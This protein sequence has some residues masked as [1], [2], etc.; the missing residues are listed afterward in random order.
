MICLNILITI[1]IIIPQSF[2]LETKTGG[3]KKVAFGINSTQPFRYMPSRHA[4]V[5][6]L[7]KIKNYRNNPKEVN[8]LVV[9]INKNGNLEKS[10]PCKD[11]I[12]MMQMSNF[13]IKYIYY[14]T[15]DGIIVKEKFSK[16]MDS[17]LTY[18]SKGVKSKKYKC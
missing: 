15:A 17:S 11:C 14:S 4:E 7:L 1:H 8:I 13:V 6:A 3:M 18:T 2:Q 16:M 10:R 9:R 5:D 12:R